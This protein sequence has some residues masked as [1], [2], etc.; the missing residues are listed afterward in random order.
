MMAKR[1]SQ[2]SYSGNSNACQELSIFITTGIVISAF[3]LPIVLAHCATVRISI[4]NQLI[5]NLFQLNECSFVLILSILQIAYGAAYL[6]I[7]GNIVIFATIFVF[8]VLSEQED[9]VYGGGF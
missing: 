2:N 4:L 1:Y 9:G 3:A 8:F 6:T 7:G 5:C